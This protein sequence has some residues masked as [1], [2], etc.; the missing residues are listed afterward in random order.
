MRRGVIRCDIPCEKVD[1]GASGNS[2]SRG[3]DG[4]ASEESHSWSQAQPGGDE[5]SLEESVPSLGQSVPIVSGAEPSLGKF[6]P[7][8]G[9]VRSSRSYS[10]A[11]PGGLRSDRYLIVPGV[12]PSLGKYIL[13]KLSL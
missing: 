8:L 11:Q 2:M 7:S 1:G 12:E 6:V 13:T 5:S 3:G 10:R 4:E 9:A